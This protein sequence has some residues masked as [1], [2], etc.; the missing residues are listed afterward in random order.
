MD[1]NG[2]LSQEDFGR[3][4][5]ISQQAVSNL[6][7]RDL[8][9]LSVSGHQALLTY[10]SHLRETAAGRS[11][12]GDLNLVDERAGLAREQKIR[13]ALQNAETR[14]ELVPVAILIAVLAK[15]GAKISG[16]LEAIPGHIK[17]RVPTLS[18]D[19]IE[20]ITTEIARVRNIAGSMTIN[21]L[22]EDE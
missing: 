22:I 20:L 4:V 17:R 7:G 14:K 13:L 5:G 18:A 1:L 3:L 8:L 9:D 12:G 19:D 6:A 10:C 2:K 15:A 21:D 11:G 16:L